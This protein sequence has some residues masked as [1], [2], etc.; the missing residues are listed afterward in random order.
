M[1]HG[2]NC[3]GNFEL[4]KVGTSKIAKK[5]GGEKSSGNGRVPRR[6]AGE[7]VSR[8]A[9]PRG[10]MKDC[11][12]LYLG[13]KLGLYRYKESGV[14][15]SDGVS[16]FDGVVCDVSAGFL[17]LIEE[18]LRTTPEK[19]DY[20]RRHYL[21]ELIDGLYYG[22]N[23]I[24]IGEQEFNELLVRYAILAFFPKDEKQA[25]TFKNLFA[26]AG[27][28]VSLVFDDAVFELVSERTKE[29]VKANEKKLNDYG[30][31]IGFIY[32]TVKSIFDRTVTAI[33]GRV[34]R[35]V[36][37]CGLSLADWF[38]DFSDSKFLNNEGEVCGIR[39]K[40]GL[41]FK[42]SSIPLVGKKID[43][44]V[45][46]ELTKGHVEKFAKEFVPKFAKYVKKYFVSS[47]KAVE[48]DPRNLGENVTV[49]CKES[50]EL[51]KRLNSL[52]ERGLARLVYQIFIKWLI[53]DV[54][55]PSLPEW[56]RGTHTETD[57]DEIGTGADLGETGTGTKL[58][59]DL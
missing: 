20:S 21:V 1:I 49:N 6:G 13:Y 56:L 5:N 25:I 16:K 51:Y 44:N 18:M 38:T 23:Q 48:S 28:N 45:F 8:F 24:K 11:A 55:R 58:G 37:S 32:G 53:L 46:H 10:L 41:N 14:S 59:E 36:A 35:T 47:L 12:L 43:H 22:H 39:K 4:P 31:G 17:G 26:L 33:V 7:S 57:L 50:G 3:N 9:G 29:I 19:W 42:L 30:L 27:E 54:V 2:V 52:N 15:K 40:L 34:E